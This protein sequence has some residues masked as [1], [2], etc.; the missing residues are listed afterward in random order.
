MHTDLKHFVAQLLR[1]TLMTLAPVVA[2]AFVTMPMSLGGHPGEMPTHAVA[3][4]HMT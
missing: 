1:T 3:A 4:R 2:T